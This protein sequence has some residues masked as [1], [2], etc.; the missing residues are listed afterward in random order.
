MNDTK[1]L[2]A[3]YFT[4]WMNK[5]TAALRSLMADDVAASTPINR[6]DSA[7]PFV[8]RLVEVATMMKGASRMHFVAD[9]DCA[10]AMYDVEFPAPVGHV[11]TCWFFRVSGGKIRAVDMTYDTTEFR[12]VLTATAGA[13]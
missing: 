4:H 2:A 3:R 1:T 7:D 9:G 13:R 5:D 6:Y 11:P 12:K 8:A 10:A